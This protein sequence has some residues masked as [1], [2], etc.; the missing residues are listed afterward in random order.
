[1]LSI[2]PIGMFNF[3]PTK[4]LVKEAFSFAQARSLLK[5]AAWF[6][7]GFDEIEDLLKEYYY[8]YNSEV[9]W[10]EIRLRLQT[11]Y[12]DCKL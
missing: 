4:E 9:A 6:G 3:A 8:G 7:I 5:S 2:Y 1:M 10:R 12:D 11:F